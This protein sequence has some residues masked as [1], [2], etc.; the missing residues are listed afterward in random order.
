MTIHKSKGLEFDTVFL[1][2]LGSQP[3]RGD[4]PM[5][6]WLKLPTQHKETLLL[7]SPVQA[8]HQERCDLYD[9]LGQL[10]QEKSNYEAQRVLY[11]AVTRAKSRLFLLD[12]SSKLSKGSFR[13]LLKH[14]EFT[15]ATGVNIVDEINNPLPK[16]ATLPSYYYMDNQ[17]TPPPYLNEPTG[18]LTLEIPRLSGIVAH[19]LLEWICEHHPKSINEIPWNLPRSEYKRIGLDPVSADLALDTLQDQIKNLFHDSIGSW[20]INKHEQEINEYELL[21]NHQN[22]IVTRII[23]RT[24]VFEGN[25][26]I[27]DFKTGKEDNELSIKHQQQLNDYGF[28]LSQRTNLPIQ[29]GLYYLANNHWVNWQFESTDLVSSNSQF[30]A[31]KIYM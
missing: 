11:V 30:G 29:C 5:L 1:P 12:S 22:K 13:S 10:D 4:S 17:P 15:T 25:Q 26:W 9:Y 21:V 2:G 23:D 6:R 27:I 19:L 7:V 28:Y 18:N 16:V 24:F 3:N 8:A 20:I 31:R 14:Q